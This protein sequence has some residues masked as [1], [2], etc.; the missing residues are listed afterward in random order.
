MRLYALTRKAG[1]HTTTYTAILYASSTLRMGPPKIIL[2]GV[3]VQLAAVISSICAPRVQRRLGL[4]NQ[5]LLLWIVILADIIPVYACIGLVLPFGGLRTE[6]EMYVAAT[7]FG[8]V[9][10]FLPLEPGHSGNETTDLGVSY[11]D[12]STATREQSTPSSSLLYVHALLSVDTIA[13]VIG[14]Q[15]HESSFFSLF[16]LTDKSASFIGPAVVGLIA[17][18][19]GN[20]RNGFLF[21]LVMLAVPVP[22]LLRVRV[23]A[24]GEEAI[25][26][27]ATTTISRRGGP[28]SR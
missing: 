3:L 2:I 14:Q 17:D 15:G 8:L 16:A 13:Y 25:A 6:G 19:T 22:V 1:F 18:T 27:S 28:G 26:W 20:I 7:W 9:S 21:L 5:R 24:G 4:S 11:T 10:L 23:R 12:R